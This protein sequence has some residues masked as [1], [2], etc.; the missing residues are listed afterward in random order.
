MIFIIA[1][2]LI[3]CGYEQD[4]KGNIEMLRLS[5][6]Y[7][8]IVGMTLTLLLFNR[9]IFSKWRWTICAIVINLA[10]FVC[11]YYLELFNGKS[12]IEQ[13]LNSQIGLVVSIILILPIFWQIFICWIYGSAFVGYIKT[14]LTKQKDKYEETIRNI[15]NG[16]TEKVSEEYK[17]IILKKATENK[18]EPFR[19]TLDKSIDEYAEILKEQITKTCRDISAWKIFISWCKFQLQS[20]SSSQKVENV[21]ETNAEDITL[22][23]ALEE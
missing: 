23:S 20:I 6:L 16:C 10:I 18:D 13:D 9:F 15:E 22:D 8:F 21:E 3:F 7:S 1:F 17:K 4:F 19:N 2:L 11:I 5:L 14:Q 12:K